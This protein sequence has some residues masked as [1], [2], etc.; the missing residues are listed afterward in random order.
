[1]RPLQAVGDRWKPLEAV[2]GRWRLFEA[3]EGRIAA[4]WCLGGLG[5]VEIQWVGEG[6][7]RAEGGLTASHNQTIRK[8]FYL[9]YHLNIII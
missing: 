8:F 1:M 9:I 6:G 3:V 7:E 2:G 5:E 4:P